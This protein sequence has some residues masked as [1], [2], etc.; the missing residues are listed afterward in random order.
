M[1]CEEVDGFLCRVDEKYFRWLKV[2]IFKSCG[3]LI[4]ILC[5]IYV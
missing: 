5:Q 2:G 4:L 3:T 1:A